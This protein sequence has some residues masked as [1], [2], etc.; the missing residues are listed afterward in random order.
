MPLFCMPAWRRFI[1]TLLLLG[2]LP[3]SSDTDPKINLRQVQWTAP[4]F[5]SVDP[6]KDAEAV[7]KDVRIGRKSWFEAVL[8]NGYDPTTQ[9]QQIALFNKLVDKYEIILDVDP[10]NVT[11]RGQEQPADTEERTPSSK[12]AG[13]SGTQGLAMSEEDLA[14]VKELL[15]AGIERVTNNNWQ[16]TTRLYRG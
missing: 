5:E 2:K 12:P 6:V 10:R 14:M 13:G 4:R 8:E 7:L 9:L 1:D 15:V 16:N 3:A 11:L